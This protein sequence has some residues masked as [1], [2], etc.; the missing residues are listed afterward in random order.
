V[1]ITSDDGYCAILILLNRWVSRISRIFGIF[2]EHRV[3]AGIREA[4]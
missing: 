4:S 2:P 1:L 3:Q